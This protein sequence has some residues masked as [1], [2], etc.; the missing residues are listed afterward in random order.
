[1]DDFFVD[2]IAMRQDL[3]CFDVPS[4]DRIKFNK[5][6][7]D[8]TRTAKNEVKPN[9]CLICGE[10]MP[11]FCNS[12]TIPRYCLKEIA[13]EGKLLTTAAL[14]GG[15][16]LNA[17][18]GINEAAVFK[19]VCRRCD[20]EYFKLYETPDTLLK[21]P[22]SQ[23]MGQIAAK[24]LLREIAKAKIELGRKEALGPS[25]TFEYDAMMHVRAID[26]EEDEKAFKVAVRVGGSSSK[27]NAFHLIY[28]TVLPY[29][30]P[31]AFQQMISPISDFNGGPINYSYNLSPNYR[32]EP[33][34]ICVLPSKG[35]TVV[36][37]FRSEKA[38]RYRTF[39]KQFN[40]LDESD[41][42]QAVVKLIFAYS[43]DAF[44]SKRVSGAV[45]RDE[46]LAQLARMNHNYFGFGDSFEACKRTALSV[47][48]R[49]FAI[50]NLPEPPNLL[51]KE[52]ALD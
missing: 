38:K 26:A 8:L 20:T 31:F 30:A 28:H 44:I 45:L 42:L 25:S 33:V 50:S 43:E 21:K 3:P 1:M 7:S 16:L 35:N 47:A 11:K 40:Y 22:S 15:N 49:D 18:V 37:A 5:Y 13:T 12:H 23:V 46:G 9:H 24:N 32:M 17:E 14:I 48:L 6:M 27:L 51:S 19:Q 29:T 41:K 34:H 36:M 4:N 52:Y 2:A 10:E 39:E